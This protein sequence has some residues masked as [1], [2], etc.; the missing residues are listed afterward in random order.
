MASSRTRALTLGGLENLLADGNP[1]NLPGKQYVQPSKPFLETRAALGDIRNKTRNASVATDQPTKEAKPKAKQAPK[2]QM[3]KENVGVVPQQVQEVEEGM[4][5]SGILALDDHI[6]DIDKD[7]VDNPQLVVE[8]VQDIYKYLRYMEKEQCVAADYLAGQTVILP[9]MRAVLVDWLVGVHLQFKLLPETVYTS[10]AILDRFMQGNTLS[11][12]RSTL[13]LVG[14]ASML[15]ASKYEEI[16]AP[17]VK[18]FVYI[19]DKSYSERD[20]IKMELQVLEGLCFNLGRPLPLHFLRRA[21]K[22]GGVEAI[23]HTLAKYIMELSLVEYSLVSEPPSRLAAAA[24]ALSIRLLEPAVSSMDEVWTPVLQH[25]TMYKLSE[26]TGTIQKL[27]S[28]L[29]AAPTAK[30]ST[31]FQKYSSKKFFKI[32]RIPALDKPILKKIAEGIIC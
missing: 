16:Y 32:T 22:A 13:Q 2:S 3:D 7:D 21:S 14:V 25:Y 28:V 24:L 29:V 26:L 27:A 12:S 18:D 19:T 15:I 20:I 1:S 31:V 5:I 17:E 23:T 10:V 9:K 8:Y 4:D 6:E 30:L 11:V